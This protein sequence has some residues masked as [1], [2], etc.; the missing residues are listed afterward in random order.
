MQLA[1]IVI[2]PFGYEW[3]HIKYKPRRGQGFSALETRRESQLLFAMTTH[4]C[5]HYCD[6]FILQASEL[7]PPTSEATDTPTISKFS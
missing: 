5:G 3:I 1:I 6:S 2:A 4:C 7:P